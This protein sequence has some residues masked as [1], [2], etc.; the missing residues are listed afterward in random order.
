[1]EG[2][3]P[4]GEENQDDKTRCV[5]RTAEKR[6]EMWV[7]PTVHNIERTC[8]EKGGTRR[9]CIN[10]SEEYMIYQGRKRMKSVPD[11][12][13]DDPDGREGGDHEG[14]TGLHRHERAN[15]HCFCLGG[16]EME[17]VKQ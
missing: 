9:D 7:R 11:I 14:R 16:R 6:D 4:R 5:S 17:G 12:A 13:I 15:E 1:L 3:I 8:P 2:N 10:Q